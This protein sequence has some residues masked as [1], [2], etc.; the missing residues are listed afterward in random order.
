MEN[1][2][3]YFSPVSENEIVYSVDMVQYDLKLF[4]KAA[5]DISKYISL[6]FPLQT[7]HTLHTK[8]KGYRDFF[9]IDFGDG[10]ESKTATI[11]FGWY[12][13]SKP[14]YGRGF[15]RFN[16][17]KLLNIEKFSLFWS[18]VR[19]GCKEITVKRWDLAID[20]P[21]PRNMVK[22]HKDGRNYER[23][24]KRS[25]TEY[26]G[27]RSS[28]GFVKLYDKQAERELDYPLTRLELTL[29]GLPNFPD[30][31]VPK[32]SVYK[33]QLDLDALVNLSQNDLVLL[34]LLLSS[35]DFSFYWNQLSRR[36]RAKLEPYCFTSDF[37]M[38][39]QSYEHCRDL[40]HS[41]EK[42]RTLR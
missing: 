18:L 37:S 23:H 24:E 15:I 28:G 39:K 25:L 22:L 42:I 34:K 14:D 11:G 17:N 32:V 3:Y 26:L 31:N 35:P 6:N 21:L 12:G 38:N 4:Y 40:V 13:T 30:V 41:F 20:M 29:E 8:F 10:K 9:T 27:S 33:Q 36:K 2:V 7:S 1:A 19:A 16:P 5:D